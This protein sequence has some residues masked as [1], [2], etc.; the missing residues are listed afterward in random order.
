M[1]GLPEECFS[2][3]LENNI[4]YW[5]AYDETF[6]NADSETVNLLEK[7]LDEQK[8]FVDEVK[9]IEWNGNGK[10]YCIVAEAQILSYFDVYS[11]ML[12]GQQL[13]T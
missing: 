7:S 2:S 9:K 6:A 13:I 11:M 8:D 1:K 10:T 4:E 3:F 12:N 5:C